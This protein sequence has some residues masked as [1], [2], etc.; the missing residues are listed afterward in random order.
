MCS[1]PWSKEDQAG[2]ES[3]INFIPENHSILL[4]LPVK[5]PLNHF[6][7]DEMLLC[8][9]IFPGLLGSPLSVPGP[10]A[11]EIRV[12]NRNDPVGETDLCLYSVLFHLD[13]FGKGAIQNQM[14]ISEITW[15][16]FSSS[17]SLSSN[18]KLINQYV[19]AHTNTHTHTL[20]SITKLQYINLVP[21]LQCN[22]IWKS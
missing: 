1:H 6:P 16:A 19:H 9:K 22:Y 12:W 21:K 5:L 13:P 2:P 10:Q 11:P 18:P 8:F 17:T 14:C 4:C 15:G 3:D 20:T 7:P